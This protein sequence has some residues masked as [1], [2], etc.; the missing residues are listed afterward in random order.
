MFAVIE[1]NPQVCMVTPNDIKRRNKRLLTFFK[2]SGIDEVR[3]IGN[4]N[5]PAV[6]YKERFVLSCYVKNFELIFTDKPFE[7]TEVARVKLLH[8]ANA[9]KTELIALLD[10]CEHRKVYRVKVKD[11]ELYLAGYN[12]LDKENS[13]G[14]FPVF[15]RHNPKIYYD[16][17][18]ADQICADYTDYDLVVI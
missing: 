13:E 4:E 14:K 15:S 6:I 10:N 12:F 5:C 8:G 18:Y 9:D 7:G 3:L 2:D 17:E 1:L 11:V 16:K